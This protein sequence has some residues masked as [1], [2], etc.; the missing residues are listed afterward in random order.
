M[1]KETSY[2]AEK[3]GMIEL[4]RCHQYAAVLRNV[5]TTDP[6]QEVNSE[7]LLFHF[8]KARKPDQWENQ[9]HPPLTVLAMKP[10]LCLHR[11]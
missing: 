1:W 3:L 10:Y 11:P 8:A 5:R 4:C 6:V 7:N 2:V 9:L